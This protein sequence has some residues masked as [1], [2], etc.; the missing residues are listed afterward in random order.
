MRTAGAIFILCAASWLA[1]KPTEQAQKPEEKPFYLVARP[2]LRNP[3]FRQSVVLMLPATGLPLV[4][5]I[6]VN[7]PT[8]IP[9]LQIFPQI[10]GLKAKSKKA[11]F[12][13]PVGVHVPIILFRSPR[14]P[15]LATRLFG[16]IC[17]SVDSSLMERVLKNSR[18][19]QELQLFL[20]RAQ[21]APE[22]L[23]D[24]LRGGAWYPIRADSNLIFTRNPQSLW[25]NLLNR[26]RPGTLIDYGF[27][28]SFAPREARRGLLTRPMRR[29]L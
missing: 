4:V 20:G 14:V 24:E 1:G 19:G 12:G 27:P 3:Y 18:N 5:G 16:D 17:M 22:Q 2:E 26:A 10:P 23:Q 6:I 25:R 15:K 28:F 21:W 13:G 9:L 8:R 11:Y 7:K 29:V